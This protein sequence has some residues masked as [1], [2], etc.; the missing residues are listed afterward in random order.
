MLPP[1]GEASDNDDEDAGNKKRLCFG[2]FDHLWILL[3]AAAGSETLLM[4]CLER[5]GARRSRQ[6]APKPYP[7]LR[8][9][10]DVVSYEAK[11]VDAAAVESFSMASSEFDSESL[12]PYH[13]EE[14]AMIFLNMLYAPR[15]SRLFSI[16]KVL[17]RI[18]HVGHICPWVKCSSLKVCIFAV[19][20]LISFNV[21]DIMHCFFVQNIAACHQGAPYSCP[22][23]DL[24]EL[25]RLKLTFTLRADHEGVLRLYSVDHVDLYITNDRNSG[26]GEM[27]AGIPHSLLLSNIRGETQV[28]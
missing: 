13:E 4:Q 10:A 24:V 8:S 20:T 22:D 12:F 18:E 3:Q 2:D 9:L 21:A 7:T 26:D 27:L 17:T 28:W 25:P 14:D 19:V 11:D 23:I 1:T 16:M 5:I 6:S 15:R